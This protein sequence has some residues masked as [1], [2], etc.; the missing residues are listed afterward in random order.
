M[1]Q[2]KSFTRRSSL[3]ALGGLLLPSGVRAQADFPSRP[4]RLLVPF[5]PGGATDFV[6]RSFA[7]RVTELAGWPVV[8]ENRPGAG[9]SIGAEAAAKAAADGYTWLLGTVGIMAV[10]Q[11]LYARLPYDPDRDFQSIA[12]LGELPNLF[13]VHPSIS[14]RT[15]PEF[16][17]YAA[18]QPAG[19]TYSSSG[20]GTTSHLSG[21]MLRLMTGAKVTHVP[22]RLVGQAYSDLLAGRVNFVIDNLPGPLPHVRSGA[23]RALAV[24]GP[25]RNA[26][27][28]NVPTMA[29]A[30]LPGY[31][32]T[33]WNALVLPRGVPA[34]IAARIEAATRQVLADPALQA[35]WREQGIA[36]GRVFGAD[37]TAFVAAERHKWQ[38]VVTR[39]DIK[40]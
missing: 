30:G 37:M 40:L 9:G 16:V 27:V 1:H 26:A 5:S 6:A 7:Q 31:Q 15:I 39:A 19:L 11:F 21:E 18:S 14:A 22:Y 3:A 34:P 33:S 8:V 29:E 36:T 35:Q 24:T 28:L 38:D 4:I 17:A 23:L 25:E 13:A 2:F 12:V 32:V 20:N 10:N